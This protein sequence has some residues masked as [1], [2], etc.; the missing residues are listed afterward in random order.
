MPGRMHL[1]GVGPKEQRQYEHIKQS[2]ERSGRYGRRA[3]E[4]AARTVMKQHKKK[5]TA[6]D[7]NRRFRQRTARIRH[8]ETDDDR[9]MQCSLRNL[10]ASG[11]R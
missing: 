2:A 4:V 9:K 6:R 1:R 10:S 5:V 11:S 3:E 8:R 7:N